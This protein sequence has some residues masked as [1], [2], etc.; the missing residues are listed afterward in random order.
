MSFSAVFYF[1][2][3]GSFFMVLLLLAAC[4]STGQTSSHVSVGSVKGSDGREHQQA[5]PQ[6]L[7][8]SSRP[9]R[10]PKPAPPPNGAKTQVQIL[11]ANPEQGV[12][13]GDDTEVEVT[14]LRAAPVARS[15]EDK[16]EEEPVEALPAPVSETTWLD[17]YPNLAQ[18]M[19]DY[20][21][22]I[23]HLENEVKKYREQLASLRERVEQQWG[24]ENME[25]SSAHQFVKY[26]DSYQSRG[27]MDFDDGKI[28]VETVDQSNPREH[29]REAIVTTLLTPYDAEN[30]EIYTDKA[31]NYSGPALLAGQVR[32]H[33]GVEVRWEWRAKRY[34]D[35]LV[36]NEI[37]QVER[38]GRTVYQVEIPLVAGHNQVRGQ[39][40]EHLVRDAGRRYQ[41]DE[42]LLYALMETESHFNPYAM[43]HIPAYG[44]M[45]VVPATAGRD[46][47]QRIRQRSDQPDQNTL[48]KP[49]E[50][51]DIGAAYISILRDVYL[52]G[53][54]H[55]QSREYA[56]ISAY[57]GGA[58][59]VLRT[60][61]KDR[62]QAVE[63]INSLSPQQV[64]DRLHR[65]HPRA[66]A[67]GY[68]KKVTEALG[69]YR[70]LASAQ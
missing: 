54:R 70:S 58:G 41:V 65:Q 39:K 29:L 31:I 45:Q 26:T 68:I 52:K 9:V 35:Y 22:V 28:V 69:R 37:Q 38:A 43:S 21:E 11:P 32:D 8:P 3:L 40:Y 5:R 16:V 46:V 67:R 10:Q 60:F 19:Q 62:R 47:Y 15:E 18:D 33:E 42:A 6:S 56:I 23:E 48:F 2:R 50:N 57:N 63:V 27:A 30:P 13:L 51:I 34:A 1:F 4:Q 24:Q 64:Y 55:P 44:L 17:R 20:Q 14:S 12:P 59:N 53:V 61:H 25:A 7:E 66:E 49:A 36:E